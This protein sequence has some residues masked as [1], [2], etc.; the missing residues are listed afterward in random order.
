MTNGLRENRARREIKSVTKNAHSNPTGS[1]LVKQIR[2]EL[3][4]YFIKKKHTTKYVQLACCIRVVLK[5]S[6]LT[7]ARTRKAV[8]LVKAGCLNL[9]K[10]RKGL[11]F[12]K[13]KDNPFFFKQPSFPK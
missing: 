5:K 6:E 4:D 2:V 3:K 12:L 13:K 10:M 8:C 11:F 9:V 1:F 7:V